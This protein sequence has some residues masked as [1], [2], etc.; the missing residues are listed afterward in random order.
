MNL[1]KNMD[2]N[3]HLKWDYIHLKETLK[4]TPPHPDPGNLVYHCGGV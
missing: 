4:E 2:L 3:Y 1:K